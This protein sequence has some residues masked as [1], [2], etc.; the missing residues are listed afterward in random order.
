MD[1]PTGISKVQTDA[2]DTTSLRYCQIL[3][4]DSDA[5]AIIQY[6]I[7]TICSLNFLEKKMR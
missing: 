7:V 3:A 4:M 1:L 2:I 6:S 5:I